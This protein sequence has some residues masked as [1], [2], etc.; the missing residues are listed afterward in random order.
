HAQRKYDSNKT[1][2]HQFI[3]A[4]RQKHEAA[5]VIQAFWKGFLLRKKLA[6]ALAAVKSDEVEDEYE[7][8]NVDAFTF[9]EFSRPSDSSE[10]SNSLPLSPQEVWQWSRSHSAENIHFRSRSGKGTMS[11]LSDWKE[12]EKFLFMSEKEEKI[13]E[14]WGFKDISTA[15]LMLKRAH[16]MKP[17]K[18]SN[19][20]LDP[21]VRLAL[22]KNNENKHLCVKPPRKTQPINAGYFEGKPCKQRRHGFRP[23]FHGQWKCFD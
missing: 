1:D 13:S 7:E 11:Q 6:S 2:N 15:Q 14:E 3:E 8:I 9:S 21:A 12:K 23:C 10:P 5:T 4:L 20:S 16:K 19:K 17:K 18:Y 22:F